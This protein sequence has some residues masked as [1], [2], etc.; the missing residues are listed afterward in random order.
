MGG[1]TGGNWISRKAYEY[2]PAFCFKPSEQDRVA[3]FATF[4][5]S[6]NHLERYLKYLQRR[7]YMVNIWRK[8]QYPID[9]CRQINKLSIIDMKSTADN[10]NLNNFTEFNFNESLE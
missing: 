7:A 4:G 3:I 10:I 8:N 1:K 9:T 6:D 2:L 5:K